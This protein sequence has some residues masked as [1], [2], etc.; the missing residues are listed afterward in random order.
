M[1]KRPTERKQERLDENITRRLWLESCQF[2]AFFFNSLSKKQSMRSSLRSL[3][4]TSFSTFYQHNLHYDHFKKNVSPQL[5]SWKSLQTSNITW[6]PRNEIIIKHMLFL[7][8]RNQRYA[9]RNNFKYLRHRRKL[10]SWYCLVVH[11]FISYHANSLSNKHVILSFNYDIR[12]KIN[13]HFL[14]FR[15][16]L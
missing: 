3:K 11:F 2:E 5:E 8:K 14:K 12:I 4:S 6:K 9:F 15:L 13:L 1:G 16:D 7:L 10:E